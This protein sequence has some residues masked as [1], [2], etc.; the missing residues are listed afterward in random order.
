VVLLV[1]EFALILRASK[2]TGATNAV[3]PEAAGV[4]CQLSLCFLK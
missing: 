1:A 3:A 2:Q 4:D